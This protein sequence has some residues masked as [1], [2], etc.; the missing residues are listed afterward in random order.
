MLGLDIKLKGHRRMI[1]P[2]VVQAVQVGLE[3]AVL[4]FSPGQIRSSDRYP[5]ITIMGNLKKYVMMEGHSGWS[6][7]P[8]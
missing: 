4:S 7:C 6:Y 2:E 1:D 5:E 8:N 3:S